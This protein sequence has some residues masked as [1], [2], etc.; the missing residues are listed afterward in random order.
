MSDDLL[1]PLLPPFRVHVY[2]DTSALRRE[3]NLDTDSWK[4]F[5][6]L[7]E[8][9]II[10]VYIHDLVGRELVSGVMDDYQQAWRSKNRDLRNG[11]EW[12]A[13]ADNHQHLQ[14][15]ITKLSGLSEEAVREGFI[16]WCDQIG[17]QM[18]SIDPSDTLEVWKRYFGHNSPFKQRKHRQDIPDAFVFVR[19]LS[20]KE[21][22]AMPLHVICSD[23]E[24]RGAFEKA[25]MVAHETIGAFITSQSVKDSIR[26]SEEASRRAQTE[27]HWRAVAIQAI[28]NQYSDI[29]NNII[30]S[31][32]RE[33]ANYDIQSKEFPI[34]NQEA[35]IVYTGE[36]D[37]IDIHLADLEYLGSEEALVP[38]TIR[39]IGANVTMFFQKG[40]YWGMRDEERSK[41]PATNSDWN[42]HYVAAEAS[43]DLVIRAMV[44]VELETDEYETMTVNDASIENI[45]KISIENIEDHIEVASK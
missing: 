7:S 10:T 45:D 6:Q 20:L 25:G 26:L 5:G 15:V 37:G 30:E 2:V 40:D 1:Y 12:A 34:E 19:S 42:R 23:K 43:I 44:R 16:S 4:R 14:E 41:F 35:T 18:V 27:Q 8:R 9:G 28:E 24:L 22:L 39:L 32:R 36:P 29:E 21:A 3:H 33:L 13:L 31:L 11:I 38:A 17:A